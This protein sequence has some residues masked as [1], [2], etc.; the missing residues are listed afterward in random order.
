MTT[1]TEL[2]QPGLGLADP[3]VQSRSATQTQLHPPIPFAEFFAGI[4]LV[5]AALEP[6]G[7]EPRWENDIEQIKFAQY[8]ANHASDGFLV[9]DVRNVRGD[10]LPCG[11]ELATSSFPCID[12]SLAGNRNGLAGKHSGMFWEFARVIRELGDANRPRVILIENVTGFAS[13]HDGKDLREALSELSD[14]GYS[15]DLLTVDARH[16]VPQSRPRM[17]I[18][19]IAGDL[20]KSCHAGIPEISGVRPRWIR[21]AYIRNSSLRLHYRQ[22][23]ELPDGP[24]D[25]SNVVE[26][27]GHDDPQ[28][29]SGERHK[30]F[31]DSLSPI[32]AS[33]LALLKDRQEIVWRT[34]YRRTRNGSA[35]WEIRRDGIAGCLRTTGGGSSKQALVGAGKGQVQVRWMTAREYAR[36]MGAGNYVLRG[37]TATQAQFG[38]GDAVVVDV[39]RWIGEHYLVPV[40]RPDA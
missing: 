40:L 24:I 22:L 15:C 4:G 39:V 16:F 31:I 19:G 7:F 37:G 10:Q 17:F 1:G 6:L 8:A 3:D 32:Q 2:L 25:L 9:D 18:V 14:L 29:W 13:S 30:A 23:P 12:L 26:S 11:L 35:T 36:L 20:P 33:R 27:I 28:W 34:A 38:F 5:R 21:D